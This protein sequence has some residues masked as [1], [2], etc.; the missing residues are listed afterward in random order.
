ML[1][2]TKEEYFKYRGINLEIELKN[3]ATDN[4]S[5]AVEIFLQNVQDDVIMYMDL[6]YFVDVN[7]LDAEVMKK[8]LIHQVD[9]LRRNGDL[10]LDSDNNTGYV[11]APKAYT[12]LKMNGYANV[13]TGKDGYNYGN[14]F[15][16]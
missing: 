15:K 10:S 2:L 11:L 12:V 6:H 13:Q 8:A 3:S 16:H 5:N 4:P 9:Y 1:Y 14:K 7:N